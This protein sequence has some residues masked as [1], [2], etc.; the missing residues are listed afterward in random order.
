MT[1]EGTMAG[2]TTAGSVV[3][4]RMGA[5]ARLTLR[6]IEQLFSELSDNAR[7]RYVVAQQRA[8][9]RRALHHERRDN[10]LYRACSKAH[11]ET[12]PAM[13]FAKQLGRL[14]MAGATEA[15]LTQLAEFP[16][17]VVR[18]MCGGTAR[19]LDEID[20]EEQRLDGPEDERQLRRRIMERQP[21]GL[22]AAM[23]REEA[24][25]CARLSAI[26]LEREHALMLLAVQAEQGMVA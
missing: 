5:R 19:S 3:Q 15:E 16:M 9:L 6:W 20:M 11:A 26:Y 12:S 17:V 13:T 18:R 8:E 7:R 4:G 10:P 24:A 2:T 14:F 25:E 1:G 22:S 21:R 23:L